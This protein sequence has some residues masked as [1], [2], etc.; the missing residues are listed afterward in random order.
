MVL[1]NAA[2]EA[3]NKALG[4]NEAGDS[5][6]IL[7]TLD[8]PGMVLNPGFLSNEDE[9]MLL[10][11]EAYIGKLAKGIVNALDEVIIE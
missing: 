10:C 3:K 1:R 2:T 5:E 4:I 11:D 8:I 7:K 6:V 9:A